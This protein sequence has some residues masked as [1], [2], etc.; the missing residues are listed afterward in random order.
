MESHAIL[1]F[2]KFFSFSTG[3]CQIPRVYADAGIPGY[4]L[5]HQA[6]TAQKKRKLKTQVS[7]FQ[8]EVRHSK[9]KLGIQKSS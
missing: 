8:N 5:S 3:L 9:L 2:L 1:A 7:Y 4:Y 6:E